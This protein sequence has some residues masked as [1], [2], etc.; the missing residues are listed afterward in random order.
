[1]SDDNGCLLGY[2]ILACIVII[3]VIAL[4]VLCL[5]FRWVPLESGW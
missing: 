3:A 5:A 2:L 1:M 4:A